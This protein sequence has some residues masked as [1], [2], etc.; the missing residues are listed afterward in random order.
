MSGGFTGLNYGVPPQRVCAIQDNVSYATYTHS[1]REHCRCQKASVN[2][3][4]SRSSTAD[5]P[6]VAAAGC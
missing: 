4:T 3:P 6:T 2:L 1:R 5:D